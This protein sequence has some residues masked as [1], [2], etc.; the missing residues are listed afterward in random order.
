MEGLAVPPTASGGSSGGSGRDRR[1]RATS[2]HRG[3]RAWVS[4]LRAAQGV[5]G[6]KSS[7]RRAPRVCPMQRQT[8]E[9]ETEVYL[10]PARVRI[11]R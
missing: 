3:S 8:A 11:R 7:P 5:E 10:M 6:A 9:V 2:N 1:Q 4:W